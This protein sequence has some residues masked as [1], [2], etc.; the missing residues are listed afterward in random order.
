LFIQREQGDLKETLMTLSNYRFYLEEI[1][2]DSNNANNH[3]K[4][5]SSNSFNDIN[6]D[7]NN[8]NHTN[9]NHSNENLNSNVQFSF[10]SKKSSFNFI[11]IL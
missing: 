6:Q 10:L 11:K 3:L 2:Q 1:N 5:H 4:N 8:P 9:T 7:S